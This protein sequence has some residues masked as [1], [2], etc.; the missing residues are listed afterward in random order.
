MVT[1]EKCVDE[2]TGNS[3][4]MRQWDRLKGTTFTRPGTIERQIDEATGKLV[5]DVQELMDFIRDHIWR[6]TCTATK[7]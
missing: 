4:F 3:E 7:K 1:F 6:P 5:T 2:V